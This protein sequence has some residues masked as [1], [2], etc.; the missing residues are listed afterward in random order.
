MGSFEERLQLA[1]KLEFNFIDLFNRYFSGEFQIVKYGIET[2]KLSSVHGVLRNC[3]DA[4]SHFVRYIPDSV[5]VE[6][7]KDSGHRVCKNKLI[8]FKAA[9]TGVR[10]DSFFRS[11]RSQCPDVPFGGK[12]DVFNIEKDALDLYR[13]LEEKLE[14]PVIIVAYA[15]F[16]KDCKLFAQYASKV[17]IC[18]SYNPNIRGLN[19][20]SGTFLYNVSLKTFDSL[21]SFLINEFGLERKRV[22]DFVRDLERLLEG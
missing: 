16:K 22:F 17:G 18:N 7:K 11:I 19:E 20:G 14:V 2:T 21:S 10:K 8:E 13:N 12:D 5:L 6:E 4:T 9:E 15:S 1:G 3:H